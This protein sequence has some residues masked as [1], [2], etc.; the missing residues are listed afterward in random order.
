[1]STVGSWLVSASLTIIFVNGDWTNP[2]LSEAVSPSP[3]C[4]ASLSF[5]ERAYDLTYNQITKLQEAVF[6]YQGLTG[7]DSL[8]VKALNIPPYQWWSEALHGVA[9]SPGVESNTL[10]I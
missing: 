7:S 9:L 8:G 1:M 4:N 6:D 3:F 2:C 10:C 5:E